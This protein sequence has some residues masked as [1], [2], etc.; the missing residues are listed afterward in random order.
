[1]PDKTY[2]TLTLQLGEPLAHLRLN[3][4]ALLNRF[5]EI[6]HVEFIQALNAVAND[7]TARV[8]ILSA[9]GK[10]F[11]A[12]G[13]FDEII[14]AA[15]S[16]EIR[17]KMTWLART[18]FNALTDLP[19]P[20][21][22]AV[23]GAA[24]GLGTTIMSLCD[25]VVASRT[26]RISDPHVSIGLVAGD[27]GIIGWTQSVGINRAKRYLLTGEAI[28]AEQAYQMGLV[29]DLTDSPDGVLP[30]AR[31]IGELIAHLPVAGV[32]GTKRAFARLTHEKA[33]LVLEL[34]LA[35]EMESM[36]RPD[37][38]NTINQLRR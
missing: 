16:S 19:V 37:V 14:A 1:M 25:V 17:S 29:T 9:E 22:A 15:N 30:R 5:D 35:Y 20:V 38:Q 33:N 32:E 34:G 36:T 3:R 24:A 4:P 21:I 26:A 23:Q 28:T 7:K 6:A 12:G 27:G 11:S 2:T 10:V 31:E 13:D 18:L 8:L